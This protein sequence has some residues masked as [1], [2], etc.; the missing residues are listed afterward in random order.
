M[1]EKAGAF[2]PT[3]RAIL[4]SLREFMERDG[5]RSPTILYA[6]TTTLTH[7]G[8]VLTARASNFVGFVAGTLK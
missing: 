2:D 4:M 1:Q 7:S 5:R 6:L 8:R 3:E